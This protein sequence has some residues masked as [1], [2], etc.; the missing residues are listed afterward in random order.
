MI[1]LQ[2]GVIVVMVQFPAGLTDFSVLQTVRTGSGTQPIGTGCL[3]H[4]VNRQGLRICGAVPPPPQIT[5]CRVQGPP[6]LCTP[7]TPSSV[8]RP[9]ANSA[10]HAPCS[11]IG[12]V[13]TMTQPVWTQQFCNH[14][15]GLRQSTKK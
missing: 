10:R 12:G 1:S 7:N 4:G 6:Y 3:S 2:A 9:I 8:A 15:Q 14:S 13:K 5:L 11:V